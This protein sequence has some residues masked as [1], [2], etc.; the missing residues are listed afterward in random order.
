MVVVCRVQKWCVLQKSCF[1]TFTKAACRRPGV[2]SRNVSEQHLLVS[3]TELG[4]DLK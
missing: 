3:E 2:V 1:Q 4:P